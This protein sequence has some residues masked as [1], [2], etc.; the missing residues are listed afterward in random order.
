MWYSLA[1]LVQVLSVRDV[2]GSTSLLF[3]PDYSADLSPS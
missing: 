3:L 1:K 2:R